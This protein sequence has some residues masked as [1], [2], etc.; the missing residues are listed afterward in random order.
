MKI[1][2]AIPIASWV[3]CMACNAGK[4]KTVT[5]TEPVEPVQKKEATPA[6]YQY[7]SPKDT[8]TL[9]LV[10]VGEAITG[11]LVYKLSGKDKNTGIIQGK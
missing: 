7:A 1:K 11:P 5:P 4:E 8:I 10:Q 2:V 6:C 9:K 3:L